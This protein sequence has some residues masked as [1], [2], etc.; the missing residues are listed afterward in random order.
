MYDWN[1]IVSVFDQGFHRARDLLEP[2]SRVKRTDH[3]NVLIMKVDDP[4]GFLHALQEWSVRDPEIFRRAISRAIPLG[5]FFE[6][7]SAAEFEEKA[8]KVMARWLPDLAG[9]KFHT[10]LH[11]REFAGKISSRAEES[12]LND[13]LLERL[14]QAGT[15]GEIEFDDPDA[16][17]AI[18]T[19]SQRA[20][21]SLW[22]R[23]QL[24]A[25]PFLGLD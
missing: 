14:A 13:Y 17:I 25:Y 20:G 8:G 24:R 12:R 19:V 18:E 4:E 11:H 10:R 15:P 23:S 1:V 6:F 21:L 16:I 7:Q 9:K 3:Y 5:T 2:I 22:T